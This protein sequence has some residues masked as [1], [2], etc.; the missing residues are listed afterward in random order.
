MNIAKIWYFGMIRENLLCIFKARLLVFYNIFSY[1]IVNS[2]PTKHGIFH[3]LWDNAS[4][5]NKEFSVFS[6]LYT[7]GC[8][9][10]SPERVQNVPIKNTDKEDADTSDFVSRCIW[11]IM[12]SST[13]KWKLPDVTEWNVNP[14]SGNGLCKLWG[15]WW[16][17]SSASLLWSSYWTWSRCSIW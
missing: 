6:L 7:R 2:F 10:A 3:Y 1:I 12:R 15:C 4:L 8:Y 9:Y 14:G 13:Y 16:K 11:K 17:Q 5:P